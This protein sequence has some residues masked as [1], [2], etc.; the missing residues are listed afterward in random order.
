MA[1]HTRVG[2]SDR[3]GKPNCDYSSGKH[4][5]DA[6]GDRPDNVRP[7]CVGICSHLLHTEAVMTGAPPFFNKWRARSNT[8]VQSRKW[9]VEPGRSVSVTP[10]PLFITLFPDPRP[11]N[12]SRSQVTLIQPYR[13]N[14]CCTEV[15][16]LKIHTIL[17]SFSRPFIILFG[18][19]FNVV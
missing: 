8:K 14:L 3:L 5:E 11:C 10:W 16:A 2:L 1:G 4:W 13:A 18:S 17:K 9:P 12:T 6:H 15:M 7:T 19:L